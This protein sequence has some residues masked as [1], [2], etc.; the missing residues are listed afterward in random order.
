L[1]GNLGLHRFDPLTK[2]F[3]VYTHNPEDP[4]N[5]SDDYFNAVFFDRSG[6]LWAGTKNGLDKFDPA[7]RT[8]KTYDQRRGMSGTVVS[9]ILEDSRD[10]LW[11]STNTGISSF[12]PKTERFSNYT[13]ADGLPGPDLTGTGCLLSE[14]AGRDVLCW[15][16]W[17]H[18]VLPGQSDS[19]EAVSSSPCSDRLSPFRFFG[20]SWSS[21]TVEGR[22]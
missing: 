19:R 15:I 22:Y 20:Y 21:F 10:S 8:F 1:G 18:C 17:R 16:Q 11:M 6:T 13:P 3:S 9:C 14:F 7:T 2:T 5:I 12:N 4:T